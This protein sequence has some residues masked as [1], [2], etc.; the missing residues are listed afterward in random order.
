MKNRNG[1]VA[2][3]LIE[4]L[5][6]VAI[7]AVLISLLL[8]ALGQ[9]RASAQNTVCTANL[10]S[11][12]IAMTYYGQDWNDYI[13]KTHWIYGNSQDDGSWDYVLFSYIDIKNKG[14]DVSKKI[15]QCPTDSLFRPYGNNIPLSYMIND[16]ASSNVTP[17]KSCPPGKQ[18]SV[19]PDPSNLILLFCEPYIYCYVGYDWNSYKSYQTWHYFGLT[20]QHGGKTN[21]LM[22]DG[23]CQ[24][25]HTSDVSNYY[26]PLWGIQWNSVN[27]RR[28]YIDG[29]Y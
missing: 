26:G 14:S 7:I 25:L 28:W 15:F 11:L 4:L 12:G 19:I 24:S 13:P 27:I 3:T 10:K 2:F 6:V 8:P 16:E 29:T 23:H 17:Y 1:F 9:A 5:V 22:V 21:Y 18:V 20:D